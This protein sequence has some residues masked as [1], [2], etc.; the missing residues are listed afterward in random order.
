MA[1][2]S[3][4]FPGRNLALFLTEKTT[5]ADAAEVERAMAN[6]G[7]DI[8]N[9]AP[10]AYCGKVG[11]AA[12]FLDFETVAVASAEVSTLLP[13][14]RQSEKVSAVVFGAVS[15]Q[16]LEILVEKGYIVHVVARSPNDSSIML[17]N[18]KEDSAVEECRLNDEGTVSCAD[19]LRKKKLR[20][21]YDDW[22]PLFTVNPDGTPRDGVMHDVL[23]MIGSALGV[24]VEM[25]PNPEPG[26]WG[27]PPETEGES[28]GTRYEIHQFSAN[29]FF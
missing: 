23:L 27:A 26:L 8:G 21:V 5:D 1:L 6:L 20:M 10:Q 18:R 13:R 11:D 19:L 7:R 17:Y 15:E 9:K 4:A 22:T 24:D 29:Q 3:A 2:A 28:N 16:L 12:K 25:V 14:R